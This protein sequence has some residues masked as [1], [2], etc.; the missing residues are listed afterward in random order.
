[1]Q[2]AFQ[3]LQN[4]A[5]GN[6]FDVDVATK[7]HAILDWLSRKLM[8]NLKTIKKVECI[9]IRVLCTVSKKLGYF[10]MEKS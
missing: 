1:M 8:T 2:Q 4:E 5:F 9:C 10:K 6:C 3:E 7:F